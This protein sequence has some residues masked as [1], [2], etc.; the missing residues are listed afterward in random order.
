MTQP[1]PLMGSNVE[2]HWYKVLKL[3]IRKVAL[4]KTILIWEIRGKS[5][6]F[7]EFE[8]IG[9]GRHI[10]GILSRF[11]DFVSGA[12]DRQRRWHEFGDS[13][14]WRQIPGISR[15]R[16]F[17]GF[18]Q[19]FGQIFRFCIRSTWQVEEVARIWRFL[20]MTS[21][22][23]NDRSDSWKWRH[24]PGIS[25]SRNFRGFDQTFGQILR[26]CIRS[27]WQQR[28]W[29]EFGDS[30][31]WRHITKT[32]VAIPGNDVTF[33]EFLGGEIFEISTKLLDR[34]CDFVS[35]AHDSRGGGTN[36][37]IPGNDVVSWNF[38]K[39]LLGLH[40][41]RFLFKLLAFLIIS[42]FNCFVFS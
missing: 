19:T 37:A 14:K 33:Q 15:S 25:R 21:H 40:F 29:H 3:E 38:R 4:I 2:E 6:K 36:L 20:E 30:W 24:V 28:K 32:I 23:R 11:F 31:K 41:V 39:L 42:R 8:T 1:N 16:N 5:W 26:F 18:D 10:P 9:N 35:G 12:H 27:T 34:F 17:R 22:S 7:P 13:W